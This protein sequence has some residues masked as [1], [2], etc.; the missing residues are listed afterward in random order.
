MEFEHELNNISCNFFQIIHWFE[1]NYCG[2]QQLLKKVKLKSSEELIFPA[3]DIKKILMKNKEEVHIHLNFMGLY[4]VDSPLPHY[5]H[6]YIMKDDEDNKMKKFL[7]IFNQR[8]YQ[9]LYLS[10]KKYRIH[11]WQVEQARYANLLTALSGKTLQ[12]TDNIEFSYAGLLGAT[13]HN[14]ISLSNMVQEYLKVEKVFVRQFVPVWYTVNEE[15]KLGVQKILLGD[16]TLL[17]NR[18]LDVN[19]KIKIE[20]KYISESHI[21][22]FLSAHVSSLISFIRR[23]L[24]SLLDFDLIFW[25][26]LDTLTEQIF[27]KDKAYLGWTFRLG[28]WLTQHYQFEMSGQS[29]AGLSHL[30]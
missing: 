30:K 18:C 7:D 12:I 24:G 21:S 25:V 10:W 5:F 27:G 16:N 19:S 29:L 26:R 15:F 6:E 23:Y 20:I 8:I 17:G 1:I 4:G 28:Q 13:N 22:D 3:A 11:I 14:A 2:N 9:L